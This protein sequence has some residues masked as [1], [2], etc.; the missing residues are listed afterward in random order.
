MIGRP[1]SAHFLTAPH[2]AAP[3][4]SRPTRAQ[5][6]KANEHLA[7]DPADRAPLTPTAEIVARIQAAKAA[8]GEAPVDPRE[9][10]QAL[11]PEGF[12]LLVR[13]LDPEP[14]ADADVDLS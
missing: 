9:I 7:L 8:K 3:L 2:R 12:R 4:T 11:P 5:S 1:H 14:A 13:K 10:D 6:A